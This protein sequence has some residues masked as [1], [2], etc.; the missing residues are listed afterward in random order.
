M[1]RKKILGN[2]MLVAA[3]ADLATKVAADELQAR[4]QRAAEERAAE[5][6]QKRQDDLA[7]NQIYARE[8]GVDL[9]AAS[10]LRRRRNRLIGYAV[11]GVAATAGLAYFA[12]KAM[13]L[14][15]V[16]DE[17]KDLAAKI[18]P[19]LL[20][21]NK[22]L[23][24]IIQGFTFGLYPPSVEDMKQER[25]KI[26]LAAAEMVTDFAEL[27]KDYKTLTGKELQSDITENLSA[28]T[29]NQFATIAER[30][31]K[32][33]ESGVVDTQPINA[34][35]EVVTD[36]TAY[37]ADNRGFYVV[38]KTKANYYK[39]DK[40][41]IYSTMDVIEPS[42][43][44]YTFYGWTDGSAISHDDKVGWGE[45]LRD[46]YKMQGTINGVKLSNHWVRKEDM[47]F[48]KNKEDCRKFLNE[49]NNSSY[50]DAIF[51]NWSLGG[52]SKYQKPKQLRCIA[53][54]SVNGQIV[55]K[56]TN[57]G[58]LIPEQCTES[59]YA[60]QTKKKNIYTIPK[61]AAAIII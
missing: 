7:A 56:G 31:Q 25:I 20:E 6:E 32:E 8:K 21:K 49:K 1:G 57:L 54:T 13:K 33:I 41:V 9:V 60:F 34:H 55:K 19:S 50:G 51:K 48:F 61:S 22:A 29:W 46:Y 16:S 5:R 30:R 3:G 59:H 11:L 52:I 38:G 26:V 36:Q 24:T 28:S 35:N 45:S 23:R 40:G 37:N 47:L 42:F 14:A 39:Y 58:V 17:A 18:P 10:Y 27:K 44:P 2:P 15:D 43:K 4:R 12:Y 53:N